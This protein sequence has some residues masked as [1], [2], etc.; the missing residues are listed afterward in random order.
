VR[1]GSKRTLRTQSGCLGW[2]CDH[3]VL[4]FVNSVLFVIFRCSPHGGNRVTILL[5]VGFAA[6]ECAWKHDAVSALACSCVKPDS[7]M[8]SLPFVL[9]ARGT[10]SKGR[11][12]NRR[13]KNSSRKVNRYGQAG[14]RLPLPYFGFSSLVA[15]RSTLL[16]VGSP[17][18]LLQVGVT[19]I[20]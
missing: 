9:S 8:F 17:V 7:T 13:Y 10:A 14:L 20:S 12:T 1:V 19:T 18:I 15:K 6:A 4:S 2:L 5:I 3:G 11:A 16:S